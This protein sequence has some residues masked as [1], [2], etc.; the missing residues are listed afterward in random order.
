MGYNAD[1]PTAQL[2]TR[3]GK[4]RT[5]SSPTRNYRCGTANLPP[6]R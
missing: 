3:L 1:Y 2:R 5:M 6:V 4:E